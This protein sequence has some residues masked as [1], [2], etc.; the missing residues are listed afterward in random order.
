MDILCS[1]AYICIL[2]VK[3]PCN[4]W[5]ILGSRGQWWS[6]KWH[7][8][9]SHWTFTTCNRWCTL[10]A[11]MR[12]SGIGF[13]SLQRRCLRVWWISVAELM[14]G[15]V[16]ASG[17]V[18][19]KEWTEGLL[20][21]PYCIHCPILCLA[22]INLELLRLITFQLEVCI[23]LRDISNETRRLPSNGFHKD[24]RLREFECTWMSKLINNK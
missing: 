5:T 7:R 9:R 12:K 21:P 13:S 11:T 4:N 1:A 14:H 16:G 22:Q 6:M 2:A 19:K 23:S 20:K 18:S 8:I 15:R 17:M 24:H 10:P 3:C